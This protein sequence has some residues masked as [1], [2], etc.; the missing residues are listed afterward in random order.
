LLI[1][2]VVG[3]YSSLCV[4]TPLAFDIQEA[5]ERRKAKKAAEKK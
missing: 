1:G 5:M 4:A 3:T 2:V